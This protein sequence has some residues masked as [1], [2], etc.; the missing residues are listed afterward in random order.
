MPA[1]CSSSSLPEHHVLHHVILQNS[2]H[3]LRQLIVINIRAPQ[4]FTT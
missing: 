3:N 2:L 4:Q 1:T